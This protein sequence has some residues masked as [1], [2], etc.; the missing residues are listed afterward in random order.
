LT[1]PPQPPP[2]TGLAVID[3]QGRLRLS[4][5]AAVMLP[6]EESVQRDAH[7]GADFVTRYAAVTQITESLLDHAAT[8]VYGTDGKRIDAKKLPELLR[9]EIAVLIA[10]DGKMV[11]PFYLRLIKEGS[12]IV[13]PPVAP[14]VSLPPPTV[15][16]EPLAKPIGLSR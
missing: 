11:D 5:V 4:E 9:K 14:S 6:V 10:K 3:E 13:A 1:L 12:L 16:T 2:V 7:G 15:D 8:P